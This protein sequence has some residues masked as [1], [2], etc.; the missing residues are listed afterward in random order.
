MSRDLGCC[1]VL[2]S[3]GLPTSARGLHGFGRVRWRWNAAIDPFAARNCGFLVGPLV[4]R[5]PE[6]DGMYMFLG[7]LFMSFSRV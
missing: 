2:L 7:N 1:V 4:F 6:Q 3:V 5:T